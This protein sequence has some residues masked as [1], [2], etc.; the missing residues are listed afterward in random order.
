MDKTF[1][2]NAFD[3]AKSAF[4]V[5]YKKTGEVVNIEKLKFNVSTLKSKREKL[6]AKLG[7]KYFDSLSCVEIVDD[8]EL[9][10]LFNEIKEISENID[11]LNNE[12]NF[13]KLKKVCPSCGASIDENSAFCSFCG[14]KLVF[15]SK[16]S[17]NE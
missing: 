7:K 10:A 3:K 9:K 11:E 16:D 6:Y 15:D 14:A 8:D 5:A 12:I 13:A 4:E 1:F 17:N 2:D